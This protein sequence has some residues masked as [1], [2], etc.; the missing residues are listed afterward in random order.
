[1]RTRIKYQVGSETL[2]KILIASL[3][4]EA[5]YENLMSRTKSESLYLWLEF[6][7]EATTDFILKVLENLDEMKVRASVLPKMVIK[8]QNLWA[9][10][11]LFLV[12][13]QE[14]AIINASLNID[15]EY[16]DSLYNVLNHP[17]VTDVLYKLYQKQIDIIRN[18]AKQF[19]QGDT[20]TY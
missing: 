18:S 6:R 2:Q 10:I 19:V 9:D 13:K 15:K 14:E 3:K 12:S 1:M 17:T 16:L 5:S 7:K 20:L 11:K 8:V 4:A